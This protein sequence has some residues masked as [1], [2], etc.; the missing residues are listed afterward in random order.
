MSFCWRTKAPFIPLSFFEDIR[1]SYPQSERPQWETSIKTSLMFGKYS[2]RFSFSGS[3]LHLSTEWSGYYWPFHWS[4][5]FTFSLHSL[6]IRFTF[7]LPTRFT[8]FT[9][10]LNESLRFHEIPFQPLSHVTVCTLTWILF[11]SPGGHRSLPLFMRSPI[12]F[13]STLTV[14]PLVSRL[15]E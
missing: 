1:R 14:R 15:Q 13:T 2:F 6:Y 8:L 5:L 7:S 11:A 12:A 3:Q 10:E 4:Y 9:R